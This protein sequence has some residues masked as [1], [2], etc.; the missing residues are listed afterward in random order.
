MK[1]TI[2]ALTSAC[3]ALVGLT[4]A[5]NLPYITKVFD[6]QPA[7]GQFANVFPEYV[8]G[9]TK[10]DI[11][12]KVEAGICGHITPCR[13]RRCPQACLPKHRGCTPH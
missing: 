13:H 9:D 4:H 2:M 10:A 5:D 12:K 11:L 1:K 7:P 3:A 8:N 6:F